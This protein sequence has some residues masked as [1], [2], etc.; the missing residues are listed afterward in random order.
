MMPRPLLWLL[1]ALA[2][3]AAAQEAPRAAQPPLFP[4]TAPEPFPEPRAAFE[5]V[6]ELLLSKYY[7][8]SLNEEALYYAA[9]RGMLRHVSPPQTPDLA[10]LVPPPRA[11]QMADALRG[12]DVSLG[13]QAGFNPAEG[14]LTVTGLTPGSPGERALRPGDRIQRINGE[15]L[16]GLSA[17]D[18]EKR[19]SGPTGET[20]RLTVVRDIEVL[21]VALTRE[22]FRVPSIHAHLLNNLT[23][24]IE[25]RSFTAEIAA[26]VRKWMDEVTARGARKVIL[27]LRHNSGGVF[28]EGLKV[29]EL[30]L[31]EKSIMLRTLT[32][33]DK[34][35]TFI[36]A[37]AAPYAHELI[38]LVNKNTASSSE[39]LAAA[40]QAH[41]RARL[42]GT[43][44]FGKAVMEQTFELN[45]GWRT[46]F[47]I[48]ALYGPA[49]HSWHLTGLK[50]D[51]YV[52]Q[53]I[54]ALPALQKLDINQ[55]MARDVQLIT[56]WKLLNDTH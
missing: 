21:E 16:R 20:V 23:G 37:N 27:D 35:Q 18:I 41:G 52:E 56:A 24:Y 9:I 42:V 26:E 55:R 49:G 53:N 47:I 54:A 44:T 39:V 36:S 29:A 34:L 8:S 12:L 13:I 4:V 11:E 10:A 22:L 48:G 2:L 50:P 1:L 30:F 31:K 5:Q 45:N 7:S 15:A 3:P 33:P 51:Y 17:A 38:L 19:L 25:V 14:S 43:P 40:L 32:H 6:K 28:L 46:K